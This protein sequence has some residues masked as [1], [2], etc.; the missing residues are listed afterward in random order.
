MNSPS[1]KTS[2]CL[3]QDGTVGQQARGCAG[4]DDEGALVLLEY[5][6]TIDPRAGHQRVAVPAPGLYPPVLVR[7]E[8]EPRPFLRIGGCV[9]RQLELAARAG[10]WRRDGQADGDELDSRP[11]GRPSEQ[12]LV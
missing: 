1:V 11:R 5:G 9:A 6:G 7:E 10:H 8:D 3:R 4:A 12:R 2:A